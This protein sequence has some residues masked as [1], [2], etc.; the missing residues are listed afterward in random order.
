MNVVWKILVTPKLT[1]RTLLVVTCAVVKQDTVE[2][3]I[4]VKVATLIDTQLLFITLSF[5]YW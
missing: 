1:V 2:M 4:A 3:A 5:T